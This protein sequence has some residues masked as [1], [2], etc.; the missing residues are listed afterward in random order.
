M[1]DKIDSFKQ[2]YARVT[3]LIMKLSELF[4]KYLK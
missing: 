3:A 4:N 2:K 1:H